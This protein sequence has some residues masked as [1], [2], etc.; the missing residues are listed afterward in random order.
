LRKKRSVI[1]LVRLPDGEVF[2]EFFHYNKSERHL[3]LKFLE[4]IKEYCDELIPYV[5]YKREGPERCRIKVKIRPEVWFTRS[6]MEL[7]QRLLAEKYGDLMLE[8]ENGIA[9]KK[10]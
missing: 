8:W 6:A 5:F 1:V 9:A 2:R 10:L 4:F 7:V 3:E